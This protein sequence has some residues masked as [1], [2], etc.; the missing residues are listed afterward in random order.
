MAAA[1]PPGPPPEDLTGCAQRIEV[2]GPVASHAGRED[3]RF[4]DGGV[5]REALELLDRPEEGV[6]TPPRRRHSLPLG[7]E[8]SQ[9]RGLDGLHLLAELRERAALQGAQDLGLALGQPAAC[10][11][12]SPT[13]RFRLFP[14]LCVPVSP[15]IRL[16]SFP[17]QPR[18][19]VEQLAGA[20]VQMPPETGTFL[21]AQKVRKSEGK[22]GEFE[23]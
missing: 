22:Q 10:L 20:G 7:V 18:K 5:D 6:D 12:L 19:L 23:L 16:F 2:R 11:C 4:E 14:L 8:A 1:T 9:R 17:C 21:A 3:L 13:P 15:R